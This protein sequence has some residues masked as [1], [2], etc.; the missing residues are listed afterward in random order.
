MLNA[1]SAKHVSKVAASIQV[2]V[3][4]CAYIWPSRKAGSQFDISLLGADG[5]RGALDYWTQYSMSMAHHIPEER[6]AEQGSF[7]PLYLHSDGGEV[8]GT[9]SECLR[10]SQLG[11]IPGTISNISIQFL[12]PS[13][14]QRRRVQHLELVQRSRPRY[15]HM[16]LQILHVYGARTAQ[17]LVRHRRAARQFFRMEHHRP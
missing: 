10:G 6:C 7:I 14:V 15:Q 13:G 2:N 12:C 5:A 4:C 8:Q 17:V 3:T 16:G 11:I 9:Q 1:N